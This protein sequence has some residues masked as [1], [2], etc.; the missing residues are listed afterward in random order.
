MKLGLARAATVP[1]PGSHLKLLEL[2]DHGL[3][4]LGL[5]PD[6]S[7]RSGSLEHRYW[8]A[9]ILCELR[10]AGLNVREEAP[11]GGGRTV[12]L[13]VESSG[14]RVA[15]EVETGHSDW[16][17]NVGKCL[18]ADLDGVIV[19]ATTSTVRALLTG[20]RSRVADGR[21]RVVAAWN[22]AGQA[23]NALQASG[24]AEPRPSSLV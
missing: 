3:A 22:A 14:R 9:R 6:A 19:A 15:I 11:L 4:T 20:D 10:D 21:V 13:L 1:V 5:K 16:K 18:G 8:I 17:E 24:A 7:G 12:D 23:I 2:T